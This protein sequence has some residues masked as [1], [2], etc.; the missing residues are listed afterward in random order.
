MRYVQSDIAWL[1]LGCGHRIL[2]EWRLAQEQ[3]LI[4]RC[5]LV[6]GVDADIPSLKNH[7][8]I[9]LTIC[10]DISRL[11]LPSESFD[12]VTANMVVE[13]L[14]KP[15]VQFHEIFRILKPGGTFLFHTVNAWGYYVLLARLI[16]E[17]FK[18]TLVRWF[19]GRAEEDVFPAHYRANREQDIEQLGRAVGFSEIDVRLLVTSAKFTI[20]P[21]LLILELLWIR[22]LMTKLFRPLRTN[23]IAALKK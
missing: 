10:G 23:I 15:A 20:V 18:K 9:A 16:P 14:D 8:S 4:E 1:D 5:K 13:H 6:V 12:L 3:G 22:L 17:R 19:E 2:S 11:P 21:P 7:R